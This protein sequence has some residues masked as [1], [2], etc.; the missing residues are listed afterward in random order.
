MA[1]RAAIVDDSA[2][3]GAFVREILTCWA[4]QRGLALEAAVFS[5][6]ERFLFQYAQD[7]DWDLLLLDI[8]MG[9]MDGVTMAKRVREHNEAVQIVFITG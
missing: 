5:S 1:Y 4:D 8:E 6:A 9:A 7:K 2:Q 3:D